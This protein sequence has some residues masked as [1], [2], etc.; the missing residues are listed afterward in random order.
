MP[1]GFKSEGAR[2]SYYMLCVTNGKTKNRKD[3][4]DDWQR[5]SARIRLL[6]TLGTGEFIQRHYLVVGGFPD[7]PGE[8]DPPENAM[9][10]IRDSEWTGKE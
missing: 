3:L 8:T 6:R 7:S 4:R 9:S 2:T 1:H 5:R 10:H